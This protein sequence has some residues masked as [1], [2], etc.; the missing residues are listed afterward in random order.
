L[1]SYVDGAASAYYNQPFFSITVTIVVSIVVAFAIF[2]MLSG[3]WRRLVDKRSLVFGLGAFFLSCVIGGAIGGGANADSLILAL[4][5]SAGVVVPY[6]FLRVTAKPENLSFDAVS[7]LMITV[8]FYVMALVVYIY[9]TRFAGF[10]ALS[11]KWKGR[12]LSGWGMSNDFGIILSMTLPFCFYKAAR[13]NKRILWYITACAN[14]TVTYFT[15]CRSALIA[16]GAILIAGAI[17]SIVRKDSRAQAVKVFSAYALVIALTVGALAVF[18]GLEWLFDYFITKSNRAVESGTDGLSS[19]RI[20][21]WKRYLQYFKTN[22]IFGG[23]FTVDAQHYIDAGAEAT[24]GIF[25]AFSYFA[26]N[27]ALQMLGS[28]GIVGFAAWGYHTFTI[29]KDVL[30][31]T[32]IDRIIFGVSIAA[33]IFGGLLDVAFFKPEFL[34]WYAMLLLAVESDYFK[35]TDTFAPSSAK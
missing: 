17:W 23:G 16:G 6:V 5:I 13:T 12:L 20:D 24:N 26:H 30:R 9:A 3:D 8:M 4:S 2:R 19:G 1:G 14:F 25:N 11:V 7:D 27:T 33:L 35:S 10:L 31:K 15:L 21:I 18:G 22:P 28:C 29:A 32:N 34:I